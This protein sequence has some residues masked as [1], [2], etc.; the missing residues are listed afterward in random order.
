MNG[1]PSAL[2]RKTGFAPR[3]LKLERSITID[4][5]KDQVFS[6]IKMLRSHEAWNAWSLKDPNMKKDF[7]GE[8]GTVGFTSSWVSE[9]PEVGT[10]EQEIKTIV[11]GERFDTEIRFKKPFEAE[12]LSYLTTSEVV[13]GKT[14]VRIGMEDTMEFPMYVISFVVNT[15]LGQKEK[16]NKS[17]DESL[18]NLKKI[19]EQ[20]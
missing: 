10:A 3:D 6:Q 5:P 17:M 7:K 20:A 12:F 14:E 2:H 16:M 9:D 11:E 13:P 18:A 4:R 8:D 15:C 1:A 19:L